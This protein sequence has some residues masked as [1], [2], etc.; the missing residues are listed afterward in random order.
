[1]LCEKTIYQTFPGCCRSATLLEAEGSE[2]YG[3]SVEVIAT[4]SLNDVV[5]SLEAEVLMVVEIGQPVPC[6]YLRPK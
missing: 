1:M 6:I 2:L 4:R 3:D 5:Y